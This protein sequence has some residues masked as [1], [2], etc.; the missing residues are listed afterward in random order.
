MR[1]LRL[2]VLR[3]RVLRLRVLRL[4]VLQ[5]RVLGLCVRS[6]AS[7]RYYSPPREPTQV[8]LMS[9]MS[10][11]EI[12]TNG[13]HHSMSTD[14]YA[15]YTGPPL[16]L[17]DIQGVVL[18]SYKMAALRT[19]VWRIDNAEHAR[20]CLR[21]LADIGAGACT[22]QNAVAWE[23]KPEYCLN[24]GLSADGLRALGVPNDSMMTFPPEFLAGALGRAAF[25]GDSGVNDP[26]NWIPAFNSDQVHMLVWLNAS[27]VDVLDSVSTK[28]RNE[29]SGAI[30][31][32]FSRDGYLPADHRAH[33]GFVDG[34]SQ[35]RVAGVPAQRSDTAAS[36]E[37]A[38]PLNFV[39]PGA[40][41]LGFESGHPGH[42]YPKP[43]PDA[44]GQN[45]SFA[46]LRILEQ[47]CAGF[48][49]FLAQSA[50]QTGLDA[51]LIAAKL[52]GRWR[53]G[54][55]LSLAPESASQATVP[56]HQWNQF[57]HADD[58]SGVRCPMGS[59]IRRAN[60]RRGDVAGSG[61]E[62]HRIM[63]RGLPYGA[64]FNAGNPRDGIERG[65]LG[66][67][68]CGNLRDQ[69]EFLMKDWINDGDFAGLGQDR[70]AVMG[71]QPEGGGRFKIPRETKPHT[72]LRN[73]QTFITTKGGAYF[74]LPS[75]TALRHLGE[76]Q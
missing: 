23:T 53:S 13:A 6:S 19:I 29:W 17:A 36:P 67:F 59:H 70:D 50:E 48:E 64:P 22:V 55:P 20:Q 38:D 18:R 15:A 66:L 75:L 73:M 76:G 8:S 61:G 27:S 43:S 1:L 11:S 5:L 4:R 69:F 14:T 12:I 41:V 2:R 37:F 62:T 33:F 10:E 24:I 9:E 68:V 52:I 3:L 58:V 32:M 47:D 71:N 25:V 21:R 7:L 74:F 45:G 72:I 28:L 63:R 56:M 16:E 35:P 60:P 42:Y 46:A 30:T 44:L 31:E 54:V 57:D 34:I 49:N 39:P 65:L 51:E 26:A 40:F